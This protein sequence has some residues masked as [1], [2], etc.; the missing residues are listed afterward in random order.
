M[1]NKV[2]IWGKLSCFIISAN[3]AASLPGLAIFQILYSQTSLKIMLNVSFPVSK[4]LSCGIY[5]VFVLSFLPKNKTKKLNEN[6][7]GRGVQG[8]HS[9]LCI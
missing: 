9:K 1:I 3:F 5:S 4:K 7:L 8:L 6:I 2:I